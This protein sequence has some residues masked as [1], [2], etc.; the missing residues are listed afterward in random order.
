MTNTFVDIKGASPVRLHVVQAGPDDGPL[1]ILLHGFP[2][3]WYG[4]K[5]QIDTLAEAGYCVWVPDQRGYNLS[6]KPVGIDAYSLDT[7]VADVIGLIDASGRQK[8][9][10]VGHD[11]G[12]AVAWW[13]AVSHPEHVE[14]LVVLNVPHPIVMK[15]YASS[16]IGQMIRSWYIGFFQLP[17]I[18]ETLSSAGNWSMFVRT[19]LSSSRPGTFRRAD[20]QQYKAA[21]SQP[22]AVMAMI[23]WYRASLRKPPARR[24]SIRV[25]VPTLLIWGTRDKFLKREMAQPSI[26]LCDNGRLVFLENASH[27]VQHEE[28]ER[29][30]ELIIS[31]KLPSGK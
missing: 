7:L 24:P 12:A 23:N 4:W 15:K 3:F 25:T 18:P 19:L 28:A 27:W 13:T 6:E 5:N 31:G 29:V 20:L 8:A 30:N 10:V 17:W 21:W 22:G 1:I 14:R 26:D 2:E 11:W 16:N 9:V